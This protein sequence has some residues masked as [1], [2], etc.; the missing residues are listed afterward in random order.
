MRDRV[1]ESTTAASVADGQPT[2]VGNGAAALVY[3]PTISADGTT[4]AFESDAS[5]LVAADTNGRTDAFAHDMV[6]DETVRVSE[7][8]PTTETG[9]FHAVTPVRLLDTR[10]AP[11]VKV[12][13]GE[14][15]ELPVAGV[16]GVPVDAAAVALNI[17]VTE[18]TAA[19]FLTAYPTGT[20]LPAT[21]TLNWV[22]GWTVPN[23]ATVKI[24]AN[25]SISLF[26]QITSTVHV[27]VDLSG[28]YDDAQVA[29][30]GFIGMQ[31]TRV[32]DTRSRSR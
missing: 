10:V 9:A 24:G 7:R 8:T 14:T 2:V 23:A 32:L 27:V 20:I 3:G 15:V 28:W 25:G 31:P 11:E 26:N 17:T 30:G 29:G 13:P 19:G 1:A 18:P 5:N 22:T 4:V 21:S 6:S 16:A 12:A